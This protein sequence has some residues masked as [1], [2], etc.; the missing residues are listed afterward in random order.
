MRLIPFSVCPED[1]VS[2]IKNISASV[3]P[4][5]GGDVVFCSLYDFLKPEMARR[6]AK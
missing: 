3:L 2:D 4:V 5:Y 1:A 6:N